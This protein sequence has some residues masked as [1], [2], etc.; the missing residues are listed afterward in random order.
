MNEKTYNSPT[1]ALCPVCQ[2]GIIKLTLHDF[3]C[4][5]STRCPICG[6]NFNIDKSQCAS[7]INKL[8]NLDMASREVDRLKNQNL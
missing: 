2:K 7:V 8:Q 6:T 3:L 5:N 1:G 4:G